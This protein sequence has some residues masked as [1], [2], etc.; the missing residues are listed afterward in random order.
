LGWEEVHDDAAAALGKSWEGTLDVVD[1]TSAGADIDVYAAEE[2]AV[3]PDADLH[4]AWAWEDA[5][6]T[7]LDDSCTEVVGEASARNPRPVRLT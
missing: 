2:L 5:A 4:I 3:L 1:H 6:S 7:D